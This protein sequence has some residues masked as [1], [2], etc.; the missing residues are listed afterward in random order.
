M[1]ITLFLR[2]CGTDTYGGEIT[3]GQ[4]M[5]GIPHEFIGGSSFMDK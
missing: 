3:E 2:K 1:R 4:N 5:A